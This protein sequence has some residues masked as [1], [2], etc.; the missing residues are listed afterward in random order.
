MPE[1]AMQPAPV[2]FVPAAD[3]FEPMPY[4]VV[5][6][7]T[8]AH[9]ADLAEREAAVAKREDQIKA[10][11]AAQREASSKLTDRDVESM[12]VSEYAM[13]GFDAFADQA[14]MTPVAERA[15][16]C[17]TLVSLVLRNGFTVIGA[18]VCASPDN[19]DAEEG[20][21]EARADAI[22]KLWTCAEYAARQRLM[23]MDLIDP[24][25]FLAEPVR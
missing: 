15:L 1:A 18:G 21:K 22:A 13:T 23:G 2:P 7:T 8:R 17:V 9:G 10:W 20:R 24:P 25:E 3:P 12:I 5:E 4:Q 16:R 19:Y 6:E 14:N 11:I